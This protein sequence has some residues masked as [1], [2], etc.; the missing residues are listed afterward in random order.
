MP[1]PVVLDGYH[2]LSVSY[3]ER[4]EEVDDYGAEIE[5]EISTNHRWLSSHYVSHPTIRDPN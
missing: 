1:L 3:P 2:Y 4:P 5:A